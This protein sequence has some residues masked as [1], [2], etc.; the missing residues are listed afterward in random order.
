M[1]RSEIQIRDPYVVLL[2]GRYYL[3]G[4]T[5]T[6]AWG[7]GE[8]F[9][10]YVSDDLEH[11]E[12]PYPIFRP[13][14][15][16]WADRNFWAPEMHVYR[17]GYYLFASFKAEGLC[18]GTQIL[19]AEGPL[20]PFTPWSD[21]PVTPRNWECLDGTLY[22]DD[23]GKPW[24]VFCHEW[25]QITDGTMEAMPLTADLRAAAGEP[26]TLFHATD[27]PWN[28]RQNPTCH[29][30]DGPSLYRTH[31]GKLLMLWSTNGP[32]GYT[33]GYSTSEGGVLGPWTPCPDPLFDQD[34][35]HGM[36]FTDA[37]GQLTLAIHAPNDTPNERPLFLPMRD[38][39]NG[40]ARI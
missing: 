37:A 1:L 16:F 28:D 10:A 29:V 8:G 26:V 20:G 7:K 24:M 25:L 9:D 5:D 4:T 12:G 23:N 17:G 31:S 30:T 11:F 32:K 27:A 36:L 15:G 40:L 3:Y 13:G 2:D 22:V 21:G 35:G 14:P 19:R 6:N 33:I 34:G 38:I 39:G 18:R